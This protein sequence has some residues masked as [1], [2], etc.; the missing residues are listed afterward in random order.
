MLFVLIEL[1]QKRE[2]ERKNSINN[3]HTYNERT[4][5]QTNKPVQNETNF[6]LTK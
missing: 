5:L 2:L 6:N 4:F 1:A 3:F